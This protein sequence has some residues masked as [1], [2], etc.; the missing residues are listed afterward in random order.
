[1]EDQLN[2]PGDHT[3]NWPIRHQEEAIS[4]WGVL[5]FSEKFEILHGFFTQRKNKIWGEI[6]SRGTPHPS[7]GGDF[8]LISNGVDWGPKE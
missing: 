7:L 5:P 1:L 4:L 6:K 2:Q 3:Q 8:Y